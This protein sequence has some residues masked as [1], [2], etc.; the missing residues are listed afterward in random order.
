[1]QEKNE[2]MLTKFYVQKEIK[3]AFK[4][5]FSVNKRALLQVKHKMG[6]SYF[7]SSILTYFLH[8]PLTNR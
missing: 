1:M 2:L 4:S 6:Y 3:P 8:D 7:R 5:N